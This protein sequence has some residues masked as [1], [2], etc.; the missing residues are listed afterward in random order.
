MAYKVTKLIDEDSGDIIYP[1]I[2]RECIP[3]N[4]VYTDQL[5]D[6]AVTNSKL[7]DASVST[8]KITANAITVEK[9]ANNAIT[10]EKI[11]NNVVT[12]N[13]IGF[14]L[15]SLVGSTL[16][17]TDQFSN[18]CIIYIPPIITTSTETADAIS[19]SFNTYK[20]IWEN[21]FSDGYVY[22]RGSVGGNLTDVQMYL[23]GNQFYVNMG[24]NV[25]AIT[26]SN[27]N[28]VDLLKTTIF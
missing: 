12:L 28:L 5:D 6:N 22:T 3:N 2:R 8:A 20:Q 1:E 11:A 24:G 10:E 7:S 13:K 16:E 21:F 18:S 23:N 27:F 9:I 26:S 17:F 4:A 25:S 19:G 15:Y 14:H